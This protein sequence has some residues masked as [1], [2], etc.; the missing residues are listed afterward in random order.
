M[1]F[2]DFN[3]GVPR[4]MSKCS[5]PNAVI[6]RD[7]IST[8][9]EPG[10]VTSPAAGWMT[11]EALTIEAGLHANQRRHGSHSNPVIRWLWRNS[12]SKRLP[13]QSES[14][15]ANGDGPCLLQK[16]IP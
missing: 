15:V 7:S 2:L 12:P 9:V 4:Q 14:G 8:G 11:T 10:P 16:G 6:D 3:C 5:P 13:A 1:F